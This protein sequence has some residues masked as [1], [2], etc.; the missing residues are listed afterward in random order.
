MTRKEAIKWLKTFK[1]HTG[2]AELS[3]AFDVAI[4]ALEQEP[5]E[6]QE[7]YEKAY[8][9]GYDKGW[10]DGN[11][12]G[13]NRWVPVGERL[14]K[15]YADVICCTD[16]EEVFIA[17]YLGKMNDGVDCFD[18]DGMMWEGDVIAWQPLPE[19]KINLHKERD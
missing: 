13:K 2:M 17:T 18:A 5:C 14:P 3:Q 10:T 19:R 15:E 7:I 1:G 11:F 6:E 8:K 16:K 9:E 12:I 4:E